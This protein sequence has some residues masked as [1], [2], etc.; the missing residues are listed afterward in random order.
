MTTTVTTT[1]TATAAESGTATDT[2]ATPASMSTPKA[3]EHATAFQ[4]HDAWLYG[5]LS[6]PASPATRGVLVVVGGPQYRAGSHRQFALMARELAAQGIPAFRF[7]YRGMG[8]SD[9]IMRTFESVN[10]DI[11]AAVDHFFRQ[12]P[13]MRE[14][15]LWGLCDGAS[16]SLFYAGQDARV[17]GLVLLNPW[18][19]TEQGEARAYLKHYYARRLFDAE[20]WSKILHGRFDYRSAAQSILK[21]AGKTLRDAGAAQQQAQ[22]QE[23]AQGQG[24]AEPSKNAGRAD[25]V[26]GSGRLSMAP[27]PSS[28]SLPDRMLQGLI[29]FRGKVLVI[30]SGNDLTAQEFSDLSTGSKAWQ[31]VLNASRVQKRKLADAN[32]TFAQRDWRGQVSNWTAE[33]MKSW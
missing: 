12:V 30:L 29:E 14:V 23:H 21:I 5:I 10:D 15:V 26:N 19:R 9:G 4:C 6:V 22:S 25:A 1:L 32:H 33:W 7:D 27:A 3:E 20:L 31:R 18:V 8:D 28:R 11:R 2:I 16:A 24:P 17:T 13:G